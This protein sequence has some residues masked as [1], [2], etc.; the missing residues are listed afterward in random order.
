MAKTVFI[1]GRKPE[2]E[3][4]PQCH[5]DVSK[6]VACQFPLRGPKEGQVCGKKLCKKCARKVGDKVYC[7]PHGNIVKNR[8]G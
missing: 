7:V 6:L 8:A 1:C 3:Q 5:D 4:C 2:T